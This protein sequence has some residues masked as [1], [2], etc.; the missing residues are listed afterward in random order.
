M[1]TYVCMEKRIQAPSYSTARGPPGPTAIL[2][3]H[4]EEEG[5]T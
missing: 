2:V 3:L 5:E 1:D 4:S